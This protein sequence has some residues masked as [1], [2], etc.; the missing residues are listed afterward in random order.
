MDALKNSNI[1]SVSWGDHLVF[2]EG[3]GR[4]ATPAAVRRRMR[5]WKADL[6]AG[7]IH[8]RITRDRIRGKFSHGRGYRHFSQSRLNTIEWDAYKEIP[9]YA[10]AIGLKVFLY[11]SLFD[12]GWPLLPKKVRDVSFHNK[13]HCQHV[14]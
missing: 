8:W 6:A 11:V 14:T 4:L 5:H 12:E 9:G 1:V 13:M 2:G 10:H 3:D 7:I